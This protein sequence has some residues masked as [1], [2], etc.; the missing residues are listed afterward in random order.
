MP[1][2]TCW[3][4]WKLNI[5]FTTRSVT[6]PLAGWNGTAVGRFWAIRGRGVGVGAGGVKISQAPSRD[7][8]DPRQSRRRSWRRSTR[9]VVRHAPPQTQSG[10]EESIPT[11]AGWCLRLCIRLLLSCLAEDDEGVYVE[12]GSGGGCV[13]G[14]GHLDRHLVLDAW[15]QAGRLPDYLRA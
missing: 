8:A 7:A 12:L 14:A 10:G 1:S 6:G 5:A 4:P 9:K 15:R 11:A 3:P 13:L 2:K